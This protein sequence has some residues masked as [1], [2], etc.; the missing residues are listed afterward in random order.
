MR[1]HH[2]RAWLADGRVEQYFERADS[3][4]DLTKRLSQ[5]ASEN[6][7]GGHF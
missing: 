2:G 3:A 4:G 6:G 7:V 1:E 5:C